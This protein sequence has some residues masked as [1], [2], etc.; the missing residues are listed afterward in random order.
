MAVD[1]HTKT[2]WPTTIIFVGGILAA[3]SV[4]T[5]F[6]QH[7]WPN[8]KLAGTAALCVPLVGWDLLYRFRWSSVS[9]LKRFFLP[10]AG[11]SV[12]IVPMWILIISMVAAFTLGVR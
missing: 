4:S 10:S 3:Y 7:G 1:D 6:A 12:R 2:Q 11:P 8:Q 5:F 9:G